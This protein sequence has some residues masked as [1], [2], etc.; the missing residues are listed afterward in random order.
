MADQIPLDSDNRAEHTPNGIHEVCP[1]LAYK[2]LTLVNV[3]FYGLPG[4]SD[5]VLIDAGIPLSAGAIM[6]A[7]ERR[8]GSQARPRAIVLTHGHFDHVGSLEA[9]AEVWD[10]PIFAHSLERPYL[11][12]SAAYP[13][14]DPTVGG[15]M[16]AALSPLYPSAPVNVS[17]WLR[18]LPQDGRVPEMPGWRWIHTPGH[19]PGHVSLFREADR[20]L[21]AGDAFITTRQE[22]AYAVLTQAP[23][24][25]GPPM[26]FTQDWEAAHRSVAKLAALDPEIMV[27]GHGRAMAG[28]DSRAA[29]RDLA[30]Q[31]PEVAI[32]E[33]GR[34]VRN[35]PHPYVPGGAKAPLPGPP[36][37][38]DGSAYRAP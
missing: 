15:G 23:E 13:P 19:T 14:P 33:R 34:Y 4:S 36:H 8:F 10:V 9:L 32:P 35:P 1:D 5:W 2:R 11:D 30:E 22:S 38:T 21:I 12:G 28:P 3:L 7:A 29:L 16:M 6:T 37:S 31:F 17:R 24:M 27:T 20:C 26:Y 18:T 25:H